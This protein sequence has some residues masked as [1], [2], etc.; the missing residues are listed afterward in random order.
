MRC[1]R[2]AA[3]PI[4]LLA[5]LRPASAG[6]P[7]V[8]DDPEPTDYRHFEIY[9]FSSGIATRDDTSGEA[10]ID[11]N[12]GAAPDLQLTA[13]LPGGFDSPRAGR[14]VIGP[15]NVE[16]AVKYRF[17]HQATLG[18]DVSF[19]PRVFLPSAARDIGERHAS[20]LLPLWVEKDW[21]DWSTFGGGGCE[22]HRGGGAQDF[23]LAGWALTRQILPKLQLGVEIYHQT[24]DTVGGRATTG[25]GAGA[26]YDLTENYHL[27]ASFG[28]GIENAA[29]TNQYSWYAAL[30]LTF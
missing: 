19:F 29:E 9:G 25:I 15:D 7:Y 3:V 30:L 17:L 20:L 8:T 4:A 11:F 21:G 12:Y 16:L 27:L 24:A 5:L 2:R 26:R 22:I 13:V 23:C 10:G 28:P 18:W 6:P 14:S 1:G